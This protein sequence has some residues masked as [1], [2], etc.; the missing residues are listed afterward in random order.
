MAETQ[1]T[2]AQW[3]AETFGPEDSLLRVAVRA[4]E[5]LAELLRC[6][7]CGAPAEKVIEEVADVVIVLY[8]LSDRMS[9][10]LY[11][12]IVGMAENP[13]AGVGWNPLKA[14]LQMQGG[15]ALLCECVSIKTDT[16]DADVA[17]EMEVHIR[18]LLMAIGTQAVRLAI[19]CGANLSQEIDRKMAVNR[20]REWRLDGT[21]HG[22]HV[23]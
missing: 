1:A 19:S 13:R 3:A 10:A 18:K 2:V 22:Y 6:L 23:C 20:Q 21:G 16:R 4:N 14:G 15:M 11:E 7:V 8:R 9:I 17:D 12:H 5:E